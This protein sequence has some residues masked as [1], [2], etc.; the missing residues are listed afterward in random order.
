[1]T[2][3]TETPNSPRP[4]NQV[5]KLRSLLFAASVRPDLVAKMPRTGTDG[6]VIDNEDATPA[7]KKSAGRIQAMGLAANFAADEAVTTQVFVRV[8]AVASEWFEDDVRVGLHP[9]LAGV[10]V[11]KVE[12]LEH[13]EAIAAALAAA[14]LQHL[15][16]FVGLE[17]ALGVA[18]ARQLLAH[19]LAIAGYFGAEDFV[20]DMGGTR[21]ASNNEVAYARSQVALA[22]RLAGIPVL[23]QIVADFTDDKRFARETA[24]A[25]ALGYRGKLCIHPKQVAIANE[26]FVPSAEELDRATRLL[27]IYGAALAK[28]HGAVA[29][30][31]QMIDE[32][33][34]AQ[35]RQLL[36]LSD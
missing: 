32:P 16:V 13:M 33:L 11:P 26:G 14:G 12:T 22:G 10:V 15:G 19:P 8:N 31:G 29:F 20:V 6:I 2:G 4:T 35:A 1:M 21:T 23:D 3:S 28:G 18:D 30:E 34:A 9:S 27:A 5:A 7:D 24:E 25:R 17:T 36:A